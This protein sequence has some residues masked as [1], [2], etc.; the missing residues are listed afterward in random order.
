MIE[1]VWLVERERGYGRRTSALAQ[2][3]VS[4][5]DSVAHCYLQVRNLSE[6]APT[7]VPGDQFAFAKQITYV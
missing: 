5:T 4:T 3:L 6:T 1:L 2:L 7:P